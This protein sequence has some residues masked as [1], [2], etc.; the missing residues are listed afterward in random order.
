MKAKSNI[1]IISD[2]CGYGK[3]YNGRK[4]QD[5]SELDNIKSSDIKSV[6]VI[7]NPGATYDASVC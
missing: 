6:E 2:M 5:F 4:M 3:V 1:L 7:Q